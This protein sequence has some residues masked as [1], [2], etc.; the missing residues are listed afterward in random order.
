MQTGIN[1]FFKKSVSSLV[2][3]DSSEEAETENSSTAGQSIEN[4]LSPD[5]NVPTISTTG[6]GPSTA[7]T[8]TDESVPKILVDV[9]PSNGPLPEPNRPLY[10]SYKRTKCGNQMRSFK[11]SWYQV[12]EWLEYWPDRDITT[13]YPCRLF[14]AD[15]KK[16]KVSKA[17]TTAGYSNWKKCQ[18]TGGGKICISFSTS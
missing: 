7:I 10:T 8:I 16:D 15:I 11:A 12:H 14:S 5:S 1:R 18:G 2:S 3:E 6:P 4:L 13:C 9:L 17:F